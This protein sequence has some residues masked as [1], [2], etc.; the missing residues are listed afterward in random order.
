MSKAL[1]CNILVACGDSKGKLLLGKKQTEREKWER[2]GVS[3]TVL[4]HSCQEFED[5]KPW[6]AVP[7]H[8]SVVTN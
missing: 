2:E 1:T 8:N 7:S 5:L 6:L 3:Q 4:C